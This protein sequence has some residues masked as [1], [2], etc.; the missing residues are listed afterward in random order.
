M[1]ICIFFSEP[2]YIQVEKFDRLLKICEEKEEQVREFI[3]L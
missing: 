1:L 2:K 3:F